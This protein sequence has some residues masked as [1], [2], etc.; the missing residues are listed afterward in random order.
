LKIKK[1]RS[2]EADEFD[3][4]SYEQVIEGHPRWEV[5][6]HRQD[7]IKRGSLSKAS[8][9]LWCLLTE[10]LL[11]RSGYQGCTSAQVCL[12]TEVRTASVDV[13]TA[14]PFTLKATA[15]QVGTNIP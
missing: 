4:R 14:S 3:M 9:C 15:W 2:P 6:N 10:G 13:Y 7:T 11:R 5:L 12:L 8:Y 1:H